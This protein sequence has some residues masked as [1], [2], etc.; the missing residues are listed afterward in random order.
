MVTRS[1]RGDVERVD[2]PTAAGGESSG[3]RQNGVAPSETYLRIDE[4]AKRTGLTKR[5]LRYYEELGLLD[6]ALRSEGNYRLF[7]A[8]DLD[9]LQHVIQMRDLLGLGLS[10]IREMV[11]HEL[12]RKEARLRFHHPDA[13]LSTRLSALADAER[14][15]REQLRMIEARI[16]ALDEMGQ[17]LRER[18]AI[19]EQLRA[20][21]TSQLERPQE[22]AESRG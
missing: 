9:M 16:E 8:E 21:I 11:R 12:E 22:D 4:V 5:T 20:G 7:R 15:T 3:E 18:L 14:V 6:P 10:E 19:Y 13:V 17:S 1:D 2:S